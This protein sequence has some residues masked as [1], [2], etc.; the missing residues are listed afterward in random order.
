MFHNPEACGAH[1][2]WQYLDKFISKDIRHAHGHLGYIHCYVC[3]VC[4]DTLDADTGTTRTTGGERGGIVRTENEGIAVCVCQ[5]LSNS[6]GLVN[7][8]TETV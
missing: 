3:G 6:G 5:V 4:L 2:T 8:L 1:Q 7:V